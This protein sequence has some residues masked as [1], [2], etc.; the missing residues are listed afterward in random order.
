MTYIHQK[1]FDIDDRYTDWWQQYNKIWTTWINLSSWKA[2]GVWSQETIYKDWVWFWN[3]TEV[4]WYVASSTLWNEAI[5]YSQIKISDTVDSSE[6]YIL[7]T[8]WRNKLA[9]ETSKY[10]FKFQVVIWWITKINTN[11]ELWSS[12]NNNYLLLSRSWNIITWKWW[13]Y[14]KTY[15][16]WALLDS[17]NWNTLSYRILNDRWNFANVIVN[18]EDN[19]LLNNNANIL[20]W[21]SF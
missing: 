4:K 17:V 18:S 2:L 6:N 3:W 14:T 16:A 9:Y 10:W 7:V 15:D 11:N 19:I 12:A 13:T 21:Q 5:W 20:I 1:N 8:H